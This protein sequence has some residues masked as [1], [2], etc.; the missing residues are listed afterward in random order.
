MSPSTGSI[1]PLHRHFLRY[2]VG[3]SNG[4]ANGSGC[5]FYAEAGIFASVFI[6]DSCAPSRLS[7]P[8]VRRLSRFMLFLSNSFARVTVLA[9]DQS[10]CPYCHRS[11]PSP[12]PAYQSFAHISGCY[13]R[14][15]ISTPYP[16][17][18]KGAVNISVVA[19]ADGKCYPATPVCEVKWLKPVFII[20]RD[21]R[22]LTITLFKIVSTT[23]TYNGNACLY[24][25]IPMR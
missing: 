9:H 13:H 1:Q 25:I 18:N 8:Y 5:H 10:F 6:S 20:L 4:S 16:K 19:V 12:S 24:M 15:Y 21:R 11:R 3:F 7:P 2:P 14:L 22:N 23:M 17:I